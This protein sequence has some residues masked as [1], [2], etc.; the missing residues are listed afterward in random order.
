MSYPIL[1]IYEFGEHLLESEDLDPVYIMLNRAN[2]DFTT[3][4]QWCLAYWCTYHVGV[5]SYVTQKGESDESL[6]WQTLGDAA[7]NDTACPTGARWPR[8]KERRHWRGAQAKQSW[9]HLREVYEAGPEGFVLRLKECAPDYQRV[10][11]YV[12]TH[13]GFGPWMSFKIA[14]MLEQVFSTHVNFTNAAVFMFKDPKEAA[15]RFWRRHQKLPDSAKPR[16]LEP[17]LN[18]VIQH[19]TD[20]FAGKGYVCPNGE[21]PVA[22]PEIETI[23]C[24]WK[25]HENGHYPLRNDITEL[26]HQLG[27]WSSVSSLA[28]S[29]KEAVPV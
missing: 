16:E 19:L 8:G 14:D 2:L 9:Q 17:T 25:S 7:R 21:R 3:K 12:D 27:D 20:Y 1:N 18:H 10:A 24:K 6:Y 26:H 11:N 29:L 5:A 13:R 23:L 22:L 28:Q 4:A 15:L